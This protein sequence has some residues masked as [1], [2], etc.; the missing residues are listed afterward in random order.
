[1]HAKSGF[2]CSPSKQEIAL[3]DSGE[4]CGNVHRGIAL[5]SPFAATSSAKVKASFSQ[6]QCR[7]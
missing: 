5:I 6:P 7:S 2:Q 1:M 3:S 4:R